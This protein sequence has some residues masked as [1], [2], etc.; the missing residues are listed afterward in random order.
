MDG[1]DVWKGDWW[2]MG[3]FSAGCE[4]VDVLHDESLFSCIVVDDVGFLD[5][6]F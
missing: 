1:E 5:F 3:G 6:G 4:E 2:V